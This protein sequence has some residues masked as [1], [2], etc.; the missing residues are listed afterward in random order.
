MGIIVAAGWVVDEVDRESRPC[1]YCGAEV[2]ATE[3]SCDFCRGCYYA[4]RTHEAPPTLADILRAHPRIVSD[5][6]G[7][8]HTGGGCFSLAGEVA[9]AE[10]LYV[11]SG[12]EDMDPSTPPSPAHPWVLCMDDSEN[13][14]Y[15]TIEGI[16]SAEEYAAALESA[17]ERWD[18]GERDW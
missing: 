13:G 15:L 4:G 9:G 1:R 7:V 11:M 18:A 8:W 14:E 10:Y 17:L 2:Q 3:P 5:S 12:G 6:V 16:T